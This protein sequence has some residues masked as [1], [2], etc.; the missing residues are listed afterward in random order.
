MPT[1]PS[2]TLATIRTKV[3]RL[4]NSPSTTSL[5]DAT[6]DDYIDTFIVYDMPDHLKLFDMSS[7]FSFYCQPYIDTYYTDTVNNPS[8]NVLYD[9][10]NLY[11]SIDGPLYIGGYES[12]LSQS[13]TEFYRQYPLNNNIVQVAT[14]DGTTTIFSGTLSAVPMLANEVTFSSVATDNTGLTLIDNGQGGIYTNLGMT[15]A[16]TGNFSTTVPGATFEVGQQ[17]YIG[18]TIFTCTALGTPAALLSTGSATGTYNTTTGALVITGNTE[19]PST[20][21]YFSPVTLIDPVYGTSVG[22]INYTTGYF[23]LI[24]AKAPLLNKGIDAQTVPYVASRPISML[25]YDNQFILR[26]VPDQ[27]YKITFNAFKRPVSLM[28]DGTA[29]PQLQDWWQYIAYGAAKK[30]FEDRLDMDSVQLIMPEFKEQ[31]VLV[32]RKTLVNQTKERTATIYSE[33]TGLGAS[34]WGWNRFF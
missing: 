13:R 14:G 5:P 18:N 27:P 30:I 31:E 20:D 10:Q 23:S 2:T 8:T 32:L 19:N 3:R 11:S 15:D 7:T 28:N 21:V 9:F 16:I 6:L 24:F 25:Y 34:P 4:T 29:N 12:Y 22:T 33:Q 26:P 17:F 1:Q